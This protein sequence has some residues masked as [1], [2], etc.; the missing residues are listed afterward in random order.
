ME[1]IKIEG[2]TIVNKPQVTKIIVKGKATEFDMK[3]GQKYLIGV[4]GGLST[5]EYLNYFKGI[6]YFSYKNF[7]IKLESLDSVYVV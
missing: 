5:A 7:I 2:I 1:G 3:I 4:D 6:F